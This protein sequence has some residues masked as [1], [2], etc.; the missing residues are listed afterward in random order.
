MKKVLLFI[1]IFLISLNVL[2]S[3]GSIKQSSVI[4]CDGVYYGSHSD[5]WHIV[6]KDGDKYVIKDSKELEAPSCY[7]NK[8][9]ESESVTLSKCVD[10]DTA[11]FKMS[12]GSIKTARF[13]A[14]DTPESV[15]PTK[16]VE[17]YGKEASDYTCRLLT[18]AKS[19]KVEYDKASDKED[20]YGRILVWV[21]A[22]DKMVQETLLSEGLAKVAYL[23][24]NY[25]YTSN[26]QKIESVAKSK[27]MGIWS[28]SKIVSNMD[29]TESEEPSNDS[30][31]SNNDSLLSSILETIKDL[32]LDFVENLLD[33]LFK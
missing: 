18:N 6:K 20:K 22:D 19:I 27:K 13:L 3:S 23:Y 31:N 12:D 32:I 29:A 5:H 8:K 26:L 10:G 30:N 28:D 21:Y 25:E 17:A 16:E 14:I 1:S 2:A 11:K 24:E 33:S 7:V 9:N 4:L 15:H